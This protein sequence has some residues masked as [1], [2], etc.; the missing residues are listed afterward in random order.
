[1]NLRNLLHADDEACK[2]GINSGIEK[3][4]RRHQES[5]TGGIIGPTNETD[6]LPQ[7]QLKLPL[8]ETLAPSG[9]S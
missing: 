7:R 5:R 3:E 8:T 9:V 1:M 2:Q 6:F 4:G